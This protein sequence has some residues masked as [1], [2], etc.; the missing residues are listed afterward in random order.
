MRTRLFFAAMAA[1]LLAATDL[2]IFSNFAWAKDPQQ[3]A[4]QKPVKERIVCKFDDQTGS[5]VNVR[6]VCLTDSDWKTLE[7]EADAEKSQMRRDVGGARGDSGC[8]T[9][10]SAAC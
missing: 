2:V 8:V 6:K 9:S 4:G 3:V 7:A 10:R 5:R 1:P